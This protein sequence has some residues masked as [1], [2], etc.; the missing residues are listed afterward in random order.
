MNVAR[1]DGAPPKPWP[2]L[3]VILRF[4]E[5]RN[6]VQKQCGIRNQLL[7]VGNGADVKILIIASIA[8]NGR[9]G[10]DLAQFRWKNLGFQILL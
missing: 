4:Q 5:R 10:D 6:G 3:F 1:A 9:H 7:C 2:F 8:N